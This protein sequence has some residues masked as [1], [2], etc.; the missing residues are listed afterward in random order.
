MADRFFPNP[1]PEFVPETTPSTPQEE[2][3]ALTVGDSL[4]K[5]LAMPHAP[6]LERLKRAALDLKETVPIPTHYFVIFNLY[7]D[8]N[9]FFIFNKYLI[10][11]F[12]EFIIK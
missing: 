4:P 7:S 1:M 11:M 9:I 2:E 8:F 12:V 3:E 5:L 6:L 10:F